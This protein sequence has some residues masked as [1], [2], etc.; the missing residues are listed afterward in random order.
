MAIGWK[1]DYFRYKGFFLNILNL[2]K[3]KP[4]LI[5]YI[6]LILSL[7]TIAL[8]AIFAIRPTIITISDLNN[9]IKE[10]ESTVAKLNQKINNL[11]IANNVL[12]GEARRLPIILESVPNRANPETLV[13][14]LETLANQNSL[15]II[16]FSSSD[17]NLI[18]EKKEN[19]KTTEG[20]SLLD[21]TDQ[22]PFLIT[23]TGDYPNLFTFLKNLQNL[24]RPVQIDSLTINSNLQENEKVLNLTISGRVPFLALNIK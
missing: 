6:E 19:K 9:E 8:F 5:K 2:Y 1:K 18:G 23:V 3:E 17:V 21:N 20:G 14:Q 15:S 10:K 16:S 7:S 12:Q 24:R 13:K 4:N 11:Q 22:I